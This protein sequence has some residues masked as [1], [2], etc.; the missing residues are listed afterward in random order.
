MLRLHSRNIKLEFAWFFSLVKI[1]LG[2]FEYLCAA[3][4]HER[5]I[6]KEYSQCGARHKLDGY[7]D[8]SF[9]PGLARY[10]VVIV[11]VAEAAKV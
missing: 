11:L 10:V 9:V 4:V 5:E 3:P 7:S 8:Y 1:F 2:K 6:P